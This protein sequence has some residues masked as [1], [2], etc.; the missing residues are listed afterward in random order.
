[1]LATSADK[2]A[3][4]NRELLDSAVSDGA[5][6]RKTEQVMTSSA[7]EHNPASAQALG[8]DY[9]RRILLAPVYDVAKETDLTPLTKLSARLGNQIF[10]KRED[11][12]PVHSFKLRGAYNKLANLPKAQCIHGVVAASAG[13][14]AQGLALAASKL[15]INATIFMPITTPEIK[16][17]NVRRLGPKC[18]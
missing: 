7:G 10:L 8:V 16:V 3:V 14:H 18:A 17:D 12:Q 15:G 6:T 1:M 4:R 5:N 9:L 2:G 13:N 11:Q